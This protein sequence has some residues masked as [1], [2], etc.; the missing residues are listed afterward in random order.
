MKTTTIG[1]ALALA[2]AGTS[3]AADENPLTRL[4]ATAMTKADADASGEVGLSEA[5]AFGITLDAFRKGS[6]DRNG[7]LDRGEFEGALRAQFDASEPEGNQRLD[8]PKASR[9]GVR[10]RAGF[11]AADRSGDG[12]LD[13]GE[14]VAALAAQVQEPIARNGGR[15]GN[16]GPTR[17][18]GSVGNSLLTHSGSP[19]RSQ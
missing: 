4:I 18:Q 17:A 15:I 12:R 9:A 19:P 1:L 2:W 11:K 8:W 14:Y 5:R 7:S 10:S 6:R 16:A 13:F 3:A